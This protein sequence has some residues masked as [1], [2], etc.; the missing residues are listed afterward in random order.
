MKISGIV[1]IFAG[2][3]GAYIWRDA[4]DEGAYLRIIGAIAASGGF[5]IYVE[6]L[7]REIIEAVRIKGKSDNE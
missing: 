7:K 4:Y 1:L 6:E 2:I 3:A 5:L